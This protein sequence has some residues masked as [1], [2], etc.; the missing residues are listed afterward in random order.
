ML[1][2][3]V[4]PA[5]WYSIAEDNTGLI[6]PDPVAP[7]TTSTLRRNPPARSRSATASS[8]RLSTSG[9]LARPA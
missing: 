7:A 5:H 9:A 2:I 4:S 1:T 6:Q 3:A 8:A